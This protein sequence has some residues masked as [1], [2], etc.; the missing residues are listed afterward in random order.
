MI[1]RYLFLSL[2]LI[3]IVC[4]SQVKEKKKIQI[5]TTEA[6][7]IGGIKQI[8]SIKG[9]DREKPVLLILHGGPGKSLISFSEG[10]TDQLKNEF[11]VVNWDQRETGAT[12]SLNRTKDKLT[13]DLL[14]K[15]ALEVVHYLQKKFHQKKIFLLSHSWGSVMGFDI[16]ARHPELLYAYIPVS[17][18]ID[19]HKSAFLFVKDLK[20]WALET[21]NNT[22]TQELDKIKLPFEDKDDFFLA[23]KWLFI[24]NGVKGADTEDFKNNYY[25]WM[26]TWFP[27]WKENAETNLFDSISEIKCPVYF[28]IGSGDNQSYYTIA[29]DYYKF[30]KAKNKKMFWFKESGHTIFNTEPEKLQEIIINEIKPNID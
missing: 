28:L 14:K 20:K 9:N 22:A 17:P 12:F 2:F 1:K 6:V 27:V 4:W 18:V 10:F 24:H 26:E 30:L 13:P 15:D 5:D 11:V 25:Q 19:A 8:I 23:Q 3:S 7:Q 21:K 29:E 16:A